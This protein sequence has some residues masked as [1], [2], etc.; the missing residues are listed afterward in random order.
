MKVIKW[1]SKRGKNSNLNL[2]QTL[3]LN[4]WFKLRVNA[5]FCDVYQNC[6]CILLGGFLD[7]SE[8]FLVLNW[9]IISQWTDMIIMASGYSHNLLIK[10]KRFK[11]TISSVQSFGI[12]LT[13]I[14][15]ISIYSLNDLGVY[16]KFK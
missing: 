3:L 7:I 1:L 12:L 4:G 6:V 10:S 8:S 9:R 15:L 14:M 2:T 11:L 13:L 5:T 16:S